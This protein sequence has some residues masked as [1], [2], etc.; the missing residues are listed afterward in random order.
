[1]PNMLNPIMMIDF[2]PPDT[3]S[4]GRESA[5]AAPRFAEFES[6]RHQEIVWQLDSHRNN[7]GGLEDM[8]F[9]Y[10][11]SKDGRVFI[12]WRGQQAMILKGSK[13]SSFLSRAETLDAQG[14]QLEMARITG[15]FKRGNEQAK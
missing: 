10:R 1:M 6:L 12:S 2:A 11:T 13:A 14:K 15:N 5:A 9:S 7:R 3:S 8:P 4:S